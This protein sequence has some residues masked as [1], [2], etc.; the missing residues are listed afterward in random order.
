MKIVQV[1]QDNVIGADGVMQTV[2]PM[3][4][5]YYHN[6][7]FFLS[8]IELHEFAIMFAEKINMF[9]SKK[10][11]NDNYSNTVALHFLIK[12]MQSFIENRMPLTY[13]NHYGK[14]IVKAV[15]GLVENRE[16]MAKE[17]E[18]LIQQFEKLLY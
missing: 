14:E 13:K 12:Y 17:V 1:H 5:V 11:R 9:L 4:P 2:A 7:W 3:T 6:I 16:K 10:T 8:G 15:R 18:T